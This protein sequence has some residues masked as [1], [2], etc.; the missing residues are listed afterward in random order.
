LANRKPFANF[1]NI[2]DNS[3]YRQDWFDFKK[4][5]L[6]NHVK[7]LISLELDGESEN[8]Q[9]EINGFYDDDGNKIDPDSVPVPNLCV[10]CKSHQEDD[11]EENMLCLMNRFDQRDDTDFKCGAFR[12]I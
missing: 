12:K 10:I 1:K 5:Y 8:Y 11:W 3:D 2:I 7:E 4:W 9:E 6:Q